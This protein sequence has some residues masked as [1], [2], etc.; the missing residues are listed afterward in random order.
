MKPDELAEAKRV[1]P[2]MQIIKGTEETMVEGGTEE[3]GAGGYTPLPMSHRQ[4]D[5]HKGLYHI[6]N[7][8]VLPR[9]DLLVAKLSP[10]S[11]EPGDQF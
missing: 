7:H 2:F 1:G 3:D 5:D 4:V 11:P 9:S 8:S 6:Y 10:R